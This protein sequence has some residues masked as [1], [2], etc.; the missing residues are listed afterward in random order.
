LA[1]E[2][3][4]YFKGGKKLNLDASA[5]Y[6]QGNS[7]KMAFCP[8]TNPLEDH[9]DYQVASYGI[10]VLSQKHDEPFFLAV[11]IVKP[12]L[13]FVCPKQF[14]DLYPETVEP[15][16]IKADD[17]DDIPWAGRAMANINDD[18]RFRGDEAWNKVRRA[19]LACISWADYNIGR[20]LDALEA[21]PYAGNT[22]VVL[23]SDHGYALGEKRHFRKFALWEETT[24][25]PFILWD[26]RDRKAPAGRTCSE[27]V[28]LINI[29]RTLADFAGLTSPDYVDGISLVPQMTHPSAPI[30]PPAITTWGRGNYGVRDEEWR[31]IRYFDGSEELYS[32]RND[33]DE[34]SNQA[35]NPEF[36]SVKKR[37]A[38]SL[39]QTEA[40]L[41]REGI[42][43]WN[44]VD[45]DKPD[46]E[47][48]R[49][50][51]EKINSTI[52]PP[53]GK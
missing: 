4:G 46:L 32:H 20:V 30:A 14:F 52:N 47:K 35:S 19:Y 31:Y 43:L 53:L 9:P 1:D 5:G 24:R 39:P 22:V 26:A 16:R 23:W 7:E 49:K 36:A 10:D 45:A 3:D 44:V 8:T 15:P 42:S 29:Y 2:W 17:H 28:S 37:L 33:P 18:A 21:S 34:W 25:V 51:W 11:G 50:E 38:A 27:A 13:A 48:A 12:H 41:V 6:Q 40:P